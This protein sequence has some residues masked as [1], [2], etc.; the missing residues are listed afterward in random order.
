[1]RARRAVAARAREKIPVKKG[2]Q[3][4]VTPAR[5]KYTVYCQHRRQQR[6]DLENRDIPVKGMSAIASSA[7]P[8]ERGAKR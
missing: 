1:M 4:H 5:Y 8:R 6:D 3:P 7:C 2:N